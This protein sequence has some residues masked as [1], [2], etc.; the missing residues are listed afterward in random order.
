[1]P[2][3][4]DVASIS[5]VSATCERSRKREN[6]VSTSRILRERLLRLY[7]QSVL[8]TLLLETR[9]CYHRIRLS[10]SRAFHARGLVF[11]EVLQSVQSVHLDSDCKE[12]QPCTVGIRTVLESRPYAT[13][14]DLEL[15]LQGWFL[16][17]LWYS[18]SR[19]IASG[20]KNHNSLMSKA[21]SGPP[22]SPNLAG[23]HS[24]PPSAVQ[25]PSKDDR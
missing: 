2:K 3:A 17:E 25:Q 23:G 11:A 5:L 8:R 14:A 6:L 4:G 15:V 20:A 21:P 18:R 10:R 22:R 12:M 16:S 13:F 24:M 9:S 19:D 7:R 1:M